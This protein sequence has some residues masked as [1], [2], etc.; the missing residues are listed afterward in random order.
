[1]GREVPHSF[2]FRLRQ[3]LA[4]DEIAKSKNRP[5]FGTHD[6]DVFCITR[7]FMGSSTFDPPVLVLPY[8]RLC[9]VAHNLPQSFEESNERDETRGT[10]LKSLADLLATYPRYSTAVSALRS[11]ADPHQH[12][13]QLGSGLTWLAQENQAPTDPMRL[14][15]DQAYS[16][17]PAQTERM[18]TIMHRV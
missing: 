11:L 16:H 4:P 14:V 9:R 7:S 2:V 18:H 1:M 13:P 12:R 3:D 8:A 15:R 5:G 10:A 6:R 17:L